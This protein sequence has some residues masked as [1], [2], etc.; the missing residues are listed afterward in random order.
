[1][2]NERLSL[3]GSE[4]CSLGCL[5]E[6]HVYVGVWSEGCV[7]GGGEAKE[8]KS[9]GGWHL[10]THHPRDCIPYTA[11]ASYM[12]LR[13]GLGALDSVRRPGFES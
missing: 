4:N 8:T 7:G 13:A 5:E 10:S 1:M 9:G 2:A 12:Q 3:K 6:V 11:G